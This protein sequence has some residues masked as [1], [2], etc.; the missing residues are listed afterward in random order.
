MGGKSKISVSAEVC[1]GKPV[2]RGTRTPVAVVL[3]HLLAGE[4]VESICVNYDLTLED[5]KACVAFSETSE[6]RGFPAQGPT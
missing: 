6:G 2:V 5:I 4:S 1:H 3:G